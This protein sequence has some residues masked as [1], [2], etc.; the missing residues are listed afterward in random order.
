M[1]HK[2][3]SGDGIARAFRAEKFVREIDLREYPTLL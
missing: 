1:A 2:L 3:Y